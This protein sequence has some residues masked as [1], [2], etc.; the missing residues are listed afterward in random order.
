MAKLIEGPSPTPQ[1]NIV[2]ITVTR[3]RGGKYNERSSVHRSAIVLD[4]CRLSIGTR[5]QK[6]KT[7]CFRKIGRCPTETFWAR[8][9]TDPVVRLGVHG[10]VRN[11]RPAMLGILFVFTP[12]ERRKQH[13]CARARS[14]R[15]RPATVYGVRLARG[16]TARR[17]SPPATSRFLRRPSLPPT[18]ASSSPVPPWRPTVGRDQTVCR[19]AGSQYTT[20]RC[21]ASVRP[22]DRSSVR[23]CAHLWQ[24]HE[25]SAPVRRRPVRR[26]PVNNRRVRRLVHERCPRRFRAL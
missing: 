21:V 8:L 15:H 25:S 10:V 4:G 23:P 14:V 1:N 19:A 12:E 24:R 3:E 11:G 16:G 18:T 5:V 17:P 26:Q 6:K 2:S 13:L 22:S 20:P 7:I 9:V